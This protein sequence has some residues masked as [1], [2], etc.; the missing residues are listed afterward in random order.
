MLES[1]EAALGAEVANDARYE[2][3]IGAKWTPTRFLDSTK[4]DPAVAFPQQSTGRRTALADWII[5]RRNPLTARVAVN[6]LWTRHMGE[7]LV[8]SVFDFGRNGTPPTHPRLLDWLAAEFIDSGWSMKH[9]HRLIVTSAAYRM[10]SSTVGGEA[11]LAIDPDNRSWWRRV[12][13]RLESQAVRD[14]ILSLAGTLDLTIGGPP[15]LPPQQDQSRRRSLYFFHSNNDRNLLLTT[16]DEARVSDCYRREQ[17]VVPQQALA[18]SNSRLVLD[19]AVRIAE[20][21][22]GSGGDKETG[23]QGDKETRRLEDNETTTTR[24]PE[25][26]ALPGDASAAVTTA[27]SEYRNQGAEK[28]TRLGDWENWTRRTWQFVRG[29]FLVLLGIEAS[30]AEVAVSC[31]ALAKWRG[32]A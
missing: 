28:T 30:D 13:L 3:L 6:H 25:P 22:S 23:R 16:F 32:A 24:Q 19:A 2:P 17:S 31:E 12:P 14:A 21:L 5:D 1:A 9:L 29:A 18:L 20:R 7:P 11:N 26:P 8:A 10:S 27:V 4:D 15:V